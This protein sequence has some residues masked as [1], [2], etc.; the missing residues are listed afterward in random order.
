MNSQQILQ[1]I[2]KYQISLKYVQWELSCSMWT[3]QTD[4][5]TLIV[6]LHNFVNMPKQYTIAVKFY[7]VRYKDSSYTAKKTSW[8]LTDNRLKFEC[9]SIMTSCTHLITHFPRCCW[10]VPFLHLYTLLWFRRHNPLY[11]S[12]VLSVSG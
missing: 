2:I 1:K 10:T 6:T 5:T 3:R 8:L 11:H 12:W 4:M 9:H 7:T